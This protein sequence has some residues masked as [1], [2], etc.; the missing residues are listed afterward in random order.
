MA[1]LKG[2][3]RIYGDATIDN[4]LQVS[5]GPVLVGAATSTGTTSQTLQV[6]GGTY[7][8]GNAGIGTTNPTQSLHVQ[9]NVR[10]VGALYDSGNNIGAASSVLSSTGS[11]LRWVTPGG[12]IGPQGIQGAIGSVSPKSVTIYNPSNTE[13]LTLFYTTSAITISSVRVVLT[14]TSPSVTFSLLSG[15]DRST[16]TTTNVSSQTVTSTTTGSSVTIA[17]TA[18]AINTWIWVTTSATSGTIN[19]FNLTLSF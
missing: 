16:A 3:T 12:P 14:G 2:G 6:T 1:K 19:S 4:K 7:I 15:G 18:I 17:N 11:A 5:S 9:S 8:S 13:N 10:I